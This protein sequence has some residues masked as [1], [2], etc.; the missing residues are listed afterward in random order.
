[1]VSISVGITCMGIM[2][3]ALCVKRKD[4][5]APRQ[6]TDKITKIIAF[7]VAI[8]LSAYGSINA[9]FYA[10]TG[11]PYPNEAFDGSLRAAIFFGA[12]VLVWFTLAEVI[13]QFGKF[14]EDKAKRDQ[15]RALPAS[16]AVFGRGDNPNELLFKVQQLTKPLQDITANLALGARLIPEAAS[17][18]EREIEMKGLLLTLKKDSPAL[19][20]SMSEL[21]ILASKSLG[22]KPNGTGSLQPAIVLSGD[23]TV[24]RTRLASDENA[25]QLIEK[26]KNQIE[27]LLAKY[28]GAK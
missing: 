18:F 5:K 24:Q 4:I 11:K 28:G 13:D 20:Q 6:I 8:G 7:S 10:I 21:K 9:I 19:A 23:I 25:K 16:E 14:F 22:V 12:I 1:L 15:A 27:E 2:L 26:I 3:V 17:I